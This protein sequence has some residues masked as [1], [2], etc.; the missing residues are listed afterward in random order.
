VLNK[1]HP[2]QK[3][4][5]GSA[6]AAAVGRSA[7]SDPLGVGFVGGKGPADSSPTLSTST[8]PRDLSRRS[9]SICEQ[10]P[11][12]PVLNKYHP[13]QKREA[14]SSSV[15]AGQVSR[16]AVSAPFTVG[17]AFG[18]GRQAAA[19]KYSSSRTLVGL[20]KLNL[21]FTICLK[22]LVCSSLEPEM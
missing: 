16:S 5:A 1:Y 10:Q 15:A 3:R 9:S 8:S 17:G 6:S 12:Q 2:S 18:G 20:Y 7:I 4:E 19:L 14:G 21:V 22:A 11:Y 13:S